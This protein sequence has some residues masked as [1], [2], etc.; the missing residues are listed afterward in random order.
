MVNQIYYYKNKQLILEN[1]SFEISGWPSGEIERNLN[2]LYEV[3][4]RN[5]VFQGA[6][7]RGKMIGIIVLESKFIGKDKDQLQVVFLHV[8]NYYRNKGLGNKLIEVVKNKA[9]KMG[10]KKLYISATPSKHTIDFYMKLGFR[11]TKEINPELSQLEPEDIH[12][13]MII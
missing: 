5:G 1:E 9:K 2:H 13:E 8:D 10:A 3:F 7:K 6:F 11:L 4:D 12:L